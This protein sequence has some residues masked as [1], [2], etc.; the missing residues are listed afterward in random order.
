MLRKEIVLYTEPRDGEGKSSASAAPLTND[1]TTARRSK[2]VDHQ[3]IRRILIRVSSK[4][5]HNSLG[6]KNVE[7][8]HEHIQI[9]IVCSLI[10]FRFWNCTR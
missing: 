3:Y 6:S 4:L 8:G 5:P 9:K 7:S 2:I 1:F 10:L